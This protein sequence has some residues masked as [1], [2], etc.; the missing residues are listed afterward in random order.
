MSRF[1]TPLCDQL[2]IELPILQ[3]GMRRVAGPQLVAAVSRAGG[4]GIIAGLLLSADDLRREIREVRAL[5]DRPFG[6]N[7]WLHEALLPPIVSESVPA[8]LLSEVQD[9]K[10]V[11]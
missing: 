10:S 4:L 9:R 1:R 6:V 8:A 7:L 11:V 5:T 2:G 3:S